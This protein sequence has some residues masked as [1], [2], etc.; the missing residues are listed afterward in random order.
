VRLCLREILLAS[1][2]N[3]YHMYTLHLVVL[4]CSSF[5]PTTQTR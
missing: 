1:L 2:V 4:L 5:V 3:K